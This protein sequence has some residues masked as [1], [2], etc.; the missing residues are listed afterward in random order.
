MVGTVYYETS[1]GCCSNFRKMEVYFKIPS[2][3]HCDSSA[4]QSQTLR[5]A[6]NDLKSSSRG[7]IVRLISK[8]PVYNEK[9]D[10]YILNFRGKSKMGSIKNMAL[11]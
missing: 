5:E 8:E 6:Y 9:H 2:L 4:R 7:S 10:C 11:I 1:I 3:V